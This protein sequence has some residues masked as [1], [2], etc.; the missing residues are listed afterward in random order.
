VH[1]ARSAGVV[2]L[3]LSQPA[4]KNA[5]STLMWRELA[6]AVHEVRE[7]TDDRVLVLTGAEGNFCSGADLW[8]F[9]QD[10]MHPL[11]RMRMIADTV[12]TLHDLPQPTIAKVRGVA[13]GIGLNLA[14][15]CDLIVAASDARL[16]E[17]FT[18][19]GLALDGGGSW[20]LPR[21][22]GMARAKELALLAD[23][24]DGTA[25][26]D[27]GLVN[28][29]LPEAEIDAF[30]DEWARRLAAGPPLAMSMTKKLL[31]E[32]HSTSLSHALEVEGL[33]LAVNWE[34]DDVREALAA[35]T[36][37]RDPRFRGR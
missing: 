11:V 14:L 28:R 3:T 10:D 16:S 31:N 5:M 37:R 27:L 12:Q 36:E 29:A 22:V 30:V 35:F 8:E 33:G 26:A 18:K 32:A 23:M 34:T 1:V 25:A 20:L 9:G 21:A 15:S 2:T 24:I 4:K 19:R 7:R 17:I 6:A 13:V